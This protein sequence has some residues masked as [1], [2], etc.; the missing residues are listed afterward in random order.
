MFQTIRVTEEDT[1][2]SAMRYTG[3]MHRPSEVRMGD[4]LPSRYNTNVFSCV[5]P[6]DQPDPLSRA[7][8]TCLPVHAQALHS[9]SY[10]HQILPCRE[11]QC[12]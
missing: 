6:N 1:F 4:N 9:A 5:A 12:L 11:E 8:Q 10:S 3:S 2:P 7:L